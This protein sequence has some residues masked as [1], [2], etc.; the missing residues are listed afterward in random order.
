MAPAPASP[1]IVI[2]TNLRDALHFFGRATGTGEVRPLEGALGI[3]S[4]LDYGVFNIGLLEQSGA[5]GPITQDASVTPDALRV[6]LDTCAGY[7]RQRSK[8]WSVWISDN[9][10][11]RDAARQVDTICAS[12]GLMRIS[13]APGMIAEQLKDPVREL[14][15]IDC[16]PVDSPV[17]RQH[18]GSLTAVSF[19]LP[20]SVV[21]AVYYPEQAWNGSYRGFVGSVKG[22]VVSIAAIV[23]STDTL[24]VYSLATSPESRR[25]GY[26][27]ALMRKAIQAERARTG[28]SRVVLQS[29]DAGHRLYQRMGFQPV[30]RFSVYLVR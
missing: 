8:R 3:Y 9:V 21:K 2:Q 25:R 11:D 29:T 30:S 14:P 18:F 15:E 28:L 13:T 23:A 27:E 6:R 4:G 16:T 12:Q 19:D 7:F 24:G 5:G 22:R 26:G 10:L 1:S 20:L 17:L